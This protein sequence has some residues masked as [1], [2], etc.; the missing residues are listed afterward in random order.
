[1]QKPPKAT[2]MGPIKCEPSPPSS[3]SDTGQRDPA[4]VWRLI[5][6]CVL[7]TGGK[8]PSA[9]VA[10]EKAGKRDTLWATS[11]PYSQSQPG[12]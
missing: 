5:G 9:Q 2:E 3:S 6:F 4:D 7:R 8:L 1:M 10:L 11:S 12:T